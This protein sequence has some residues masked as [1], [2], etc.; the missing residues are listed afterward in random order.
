MPPQRFE[1][2]EDS[3]DLFAKLTENPGYII[4]KFTASWCGPCKKA[5]PYIENGLATLP[6]TVHY[7]EIDIDDHFELYGYLKTKKMVNGI[8]ALLAWKSG[9]TEY[10]PTSAVLGADEVSINSFFENILKK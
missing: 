3:A 1:V 9:N 6:E 5:A 7:Y 8:P 10:I 4:V 2:I